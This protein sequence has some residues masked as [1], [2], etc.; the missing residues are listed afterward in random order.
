MVNTRN[1][2]NGQGSNPD[3]Q[4]SSQFNQLIANQNQLM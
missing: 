1:N 4:A 2:N 3:S